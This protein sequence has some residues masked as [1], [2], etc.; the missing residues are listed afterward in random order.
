MLEYAGVPV[1]MGNA[2]PELKRLGWPVTSDNDSGGVAA[3]IDRYALA[4]P[5][6][7]PAGA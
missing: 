3:A 1:V 4:G 2:V 7:G 6:G 5:G